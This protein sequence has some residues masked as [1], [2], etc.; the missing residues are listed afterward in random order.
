MCKEVYTPPEF[1]ETFSSIDNC[2]Q[3]EGEDGGVW[4]AVMTAVV[5]SRRKHC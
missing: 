3:K 5:H 1:I 4:E 2:F